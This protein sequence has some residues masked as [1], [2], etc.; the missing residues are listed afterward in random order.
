MAATR[1]L[2]SARDIGAAKA[3]FP[4]IAAAM[5]RQDIDVAVVAQEPAYS[6]FRERGLD[7]V[8]VEAPPVAS[9]DSPAAA[10]LLARASD[11][12]LTLRPDIV[13]TGLS[14]PD[15][16]ID[17]ALLA[18]AE[19]RHTCSFQDYEGWVVSGFGKPAGTYIVTH[20]DAA[21]MTHSQGISHTIEAGW[22]GYEDWVDMD[23]PAMRRSFR[24][25]VEAGK[26][27]VAVFGQTLDCPG[28]RKSMHLLGASLRQFGE[29][30]TV[31]YRKH[32][33]QV[34]REAAADMEALG[35]ADRPEAA[36][37]PV[38]GDLI[39]M[40]AGSDCA[41]SCLSTV[42]QDAMALNALSAEPVSVPIYLLS[43]PDVRKIHTD[44]SGT[45]AP[46]P[47]RQC[48]ALAVWKEDDYAGLVEQALSPETRQTV[49]R[50][51]RDSMK[52]SRTSAEAILDA[53][54]GR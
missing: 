44:D 21:T 27:V 23:I 34:D 20:A 36:L 31:L 29:P 41:I 1:L 12:H 6:F 46:W 28:Y 5:D 14:G 24:S 39:A 52:I 32:P 22:V 16:G 25:T 45:E 42:G 19:T 54:L 47:V 2:V 10:A 43:E 33:R 51:A 26:P 9:T 8:E 13:L 53:V 48:G 15:L 38:S 49:W 4:L 7:P 18:T 50:Q 40:L 11:L 37:S 17:E 30:I 35:L 3:L